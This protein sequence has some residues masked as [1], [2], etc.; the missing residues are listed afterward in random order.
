MA[1]TFHEELIWFGAAFA[2]T[3]WLAIR[4][5]LGGRARAEVT[6]GWLLFSQCLWIFG[7]ASELTVDGLP[8][9]L[10]LDGLQ[11]YPMCAS[12]LLHILFAHHFSSTRPPSGLL[13]TYATLSFLTATVGRE[14][15][16][17]NADV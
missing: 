1:F 3:A 4:I 16:S 15:F 9:K 14:R 7:Q 10:W 5:L 13:V 8:A 12:G 11:Y 6:Y 2:L 17:M